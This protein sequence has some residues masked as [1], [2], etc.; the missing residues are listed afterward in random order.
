MAVADVDVAVAD[1]R[2]SVGGGVGGEVSLMLQSAP[3]YP[4]WHAHAQSVGVG[5]GTPFPLHQSPSAIASVVGAPVSS[6]SSV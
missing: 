6:V 3:L 4:R 5:V 2:V 1:V